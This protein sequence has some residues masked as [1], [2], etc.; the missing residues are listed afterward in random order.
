MPTVTGLNQSILVSINEKRSQCLLIGLNE[1]DDRPEETFAF[2]Y[3]PETVSDNKTVNYSNQ[4][5]PGGSLPIYQWI[6]S[7]VRNISFTAVFST[8]IDFAR[9]PTRADQAY[10]SLRNSET[11][12]F[13][14]DIRT[15]VMHLR[16]Y[17]LPRYGVDE[18]RGGR[19]RT[20][21]PRK[22]ILRLPNSGIGAAGGYLASH[23]ND[24][25]EIVCI[26]MACD[27]SYDAFFPSGLPRLVTVNL[28]FEQV[29]QVGNH[30]VFPESSTILA[31]VDS[32]E[33][34]GA[35][36]HLS[37]ADASMRR[38]QKLLTEGPAVIQSGT[39]VRFQPYTIK[40]RGG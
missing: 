8:D 15:A 34:S 38:K 10:A 27:V 6:S 9:E 37:S 30:V 16:S 4:E 2:Q 1:R 19:A 13:N 7:G 24:A 32:R 35:T 22:C 11:E 29:P 17:M 26:M 25:D 14:Q 20:F 28:A 36:Q 3:F 40:H 31:N 39:S 23:T 21:A 18:A 5:I 12:S 33:V